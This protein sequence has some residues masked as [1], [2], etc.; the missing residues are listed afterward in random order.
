VNARDATS[1]IGFTYN[2]TAL[3]A[4]TQLLS[5]EKL[6]VNIFGKLA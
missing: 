4:P 3:L 5:G 2:S 1:K 6:F